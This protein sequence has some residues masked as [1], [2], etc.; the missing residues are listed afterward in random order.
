MDDVIRSLFPAAQNYTYLNSAA[1][2]PIPLT[3]IEAI[4]GQ[5]VDVS[6]NGSLGYLG[7]IE[8]KNRAR[9][10]LASMLNVSSDQVAFT[11]NTS[12]GFAAIAA[13]IDWKTG[14]N[15]VSFDGEFPSN[16]YPW[17]RV[18]DRFSVELRLCGETAGRVNIDELMSMIDRQTRVVALSSVQYASGYRAD[19]E[20]IGRAA[21]AVDALFCVDIIQ[22]LGQL[23]YDLPA[24]FVDAASGASHKWLCAPEGCGILYLSDRARDLVDPAIVGWISVETPWD[25][26]DREQPFKPTA[27]AW[28]SGTGASALFYGLE[29]SLKL[30]LD[31]GAEN[32]EKHLAEL[33]DRLCDG[34]AGTYYDIVSSRAHGER[35]AIVCIK[36]RNGMPVNDI[37]A[38]LESEKI[39]VSPRGDRLRIAPH[40]YNNSQDIDRLLSALPN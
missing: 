7:W 36:H 26:V 38:K 8:T 10:Q 29:Q 24:Q 28:E 1:V 21:R 27:L 18:R 25:F 23:P 20:R 30:L 37:T 35:S 13:G 39:V 3:A 15:I 31:A 14:D 34:V 11:R 19:L 5:L 33:T 12:D 22:G 9:A 2:S 4:N 6:A 40:F 32:I 16:F 17:R